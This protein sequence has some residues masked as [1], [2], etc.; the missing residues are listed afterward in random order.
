[1]LHMADQ[2]V[3]R[4]AGR[5]TRRGLIGGAGSAALGAALG[6]AHTS[7]AAASESAIAPAAVSYDP[8]FVMGQVTGVGGDGLLTI[9]DGDGRERAARLVDATR[10]WKASRWNVRDIAPGDCVT[11]RGALN[12]AGELELE[13]A[14]ANIGR[15]VGECTSVGRDSFE[16]RHAGRRI[17]TIQVTDDTIFRDLRGRESFG[18]LT[19]ISSDLPLFVI[20]HNDGPAGQEVAHR[21]EVAGPSVADTVDAGLAIVNGLVEDHW[22]STPVT[23][24]HN[25]PNFDVARRGNAS[26]FCCGSQACGSRCGSLGT[27]GKCGFCSSSGHYI[28]WP[29]V[30]D[31]TAGCVGCCLPENFPRYGC[32]TGFEIENS[33]SGRATFV[34]IA[35]C[36]PNPR[37]RDTGCKGYQSVRFDLTPCAFTAVGG[38]MDIGHVNLWVS[39]P[40]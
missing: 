8:N 12:D 22:P 37:C 5:L 38:S 10:Y 7:R 35:D 23:G 32:G 31:C 3:E 29:K 30:S 27:N 20:S 4:A 25:Q 13:V 36:G 26:Y 17:S 34:Q 15:F 28:A 33:C 19:V 6:L 14:W 16:I 24:R 11:G 39:A 40:T 21:V 1:M 2:L 18:D 9:F